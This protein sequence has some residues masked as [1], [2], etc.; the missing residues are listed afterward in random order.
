MKKRWHSVPLEVEALNRKALKE[1]Q[2]T[3]GENQ[4]S[5]ICAFFATFA[6]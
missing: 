2:R 1:S 4:P 3:Q 5:V 6:V